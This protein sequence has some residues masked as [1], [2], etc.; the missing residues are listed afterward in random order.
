MLLAAAAWGGGRSQLCRS[1]AAEAVPVWQRRKW[2]R[3]ERLAGMIR[4]IGSLARMRGARRVSFEVWTFAGMRFFRFVCLK[5][6]LGV[7]VC[8]RVFST[9]I[10]KNFCDYSNCCRGW[11]LKDLQQAMNEC[12]HKFF[13]RLHWTN[14]NVALN[15]IGR[16]SMKHWLKRS[17]YFCVP[18]LSSNYIPPSVQRVCFNLIL[19]FVVL[20]SFPS[21]IPL[22]QQTLLI[23]HSSYMTGISTTKTLCPTFY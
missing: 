8:S 19:V 2:R 12:N 17:D 11:G 18:Q 15:E 5:W 22:S 6:A 7:S 23:F 20:V 14:G 13:I 10:Q 16:H 4:S 1:L 21:Q 9:R 3:R